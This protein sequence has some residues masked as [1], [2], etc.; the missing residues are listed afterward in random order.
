MEEII[1]VANK[2]TQKYFAV[3]HEVADTVDFSLAQT[4]ALYGL[5]RLS[6]MSIGSDHSGPVDKKIASMLLTGPAQDLEWPHICMGGTAGAYRFYQGAYKIGKAES[7]LLHTVIERLLAMTGNLLPE[8]V[9]SETLLTVCPFL[10][11]AGTVF[12]RVDLHDASIRL[13]ESVSAGLVDLKTGLYFS[14]LASARPSGSGVYSA[15]SNGFAAAALVEILRALPYSHPKRLVLIDKLRAL[16]TALAS[17]QT[18]AGLWRQELTN[19]D[20]ME[21]T[22]ASTLIA[23]AF[24]S[25]AAQKGWAEPKIHLCVE[26]TW[27]GLLSRINLQGN[28]NINGVLREPTPG[29][30]KPEEVLNDLIGFGPVMLATAAYAWLKR[31]QAWEQRDLPNFHFAPP[32]V[33]QVEQYFARVHATCERNHNPDGSYY[34]GTSLDPDVTFDEI[35]KESRTSHPIPR[36]T[37]HCILGYLD[38]YRYSPQKIYLQ[39]ARAG[40]EW[41][42]KEQEPDGCFRLW[43]RKR[44]GQVPHHGCL[45]DTGIAAAALAKGYEF[46]KD[47]RYLAASARAA[48][49]ELDWPVDRNVNF[50][51]FAFWHLAEHYRLTGDEN[52][53]EKTLYKTRQAM[54]TPQQANGG[55]AGHNSWIWYHGINIRAYAALFNVLPAAHPFRPDLEQALRASLGYF[56]RL[57]M[58]NGAV[59]PNPDNLDKTSH[60]MF[61]I[62]VGVVTTLQGLNVPGLRASL[63]GLVTYRISP[64]SG[65]PDKLLNN[66]KGYWLFG[67]SPWYVCALGAYLGLVADQENREQQTFFA[68]KAAHFE[69][70]A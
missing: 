11:M 3:H 47:E 63:N 14:T 12:D 18:P 40:L 26:K 22:S 35:I 60:L 31:G 28:G 15:R 17:L 62:I 55:W 6:E 39:R 27:K 5:L 2:V 24:F 51:A 21:E 58:E 32:D 30:E 54:L 44:E 13:F 57:Q 64:E 38:M 37:S 61:E 41:L 42:V 34:Q 29:A 4:L 9:T 7:S 49:W 67:C 10:S 66:E 65:D 53:L 8:F 70:D 23:Y 33:R 46:F 25:A 19:P 69:G 45:F 20:S 52:L 16:L 48:R 50:N 1:T 36:D 56:T 68:H 59:H 43:T